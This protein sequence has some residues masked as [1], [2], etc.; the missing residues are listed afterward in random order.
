M[1]S[2]KTIALLF[3]FNMVKL[4]IRRAFN[5]HGVRGSGPGRT[6]TRRRTA[7]KTGASLQE[8]SPF[9]MDM[10]T[11]QTSRFKT[12]VLTEIRN[13]KGFNL[14]VCARVFVY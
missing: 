11:N 9:S 7:L 10:A 2:C 14:C 5:K 3:I 12:R 8:T 6:K 4:K 1:H 13:G